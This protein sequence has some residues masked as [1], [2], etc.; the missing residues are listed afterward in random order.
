MSNMVRTLNNC[1][2][3]TFGINIIGV[4]MISVFIYNEA[5]AQRKLSSSLQLSMSLLPLQV[6]QW[7]FCY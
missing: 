3:H 1:T 5:D 2:L 4:G 7:R 6:I